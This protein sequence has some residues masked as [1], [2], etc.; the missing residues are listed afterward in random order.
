MEAGL[1]AIDW[2]R[3]W[4]APWRAEGE[5]AA[6]RVQA[7]A[8]VADAL[9]AQ[10]AAG[11]CRGTPATEPGVA[12][13]P[14][15]CLPAGQAYESFI[16]THRQVPTRDN[17]H[18][19]FNGLVWL[20]YPEAKRRMNQLQAEAIAAQGVGAVRGP[21]RDA[22]TVFDENGALW[23]APAPLRAALLARDW[24]GLFVRHR[25]LWAQARL[26]LFGHALLEKLVTPY[27]SVI[28]HVLVLPEQPP[29]HPAD[30]AWLA[31]ALQ[32]GVWR[33]KPFA[34]LPVL[35][36][37]GWWA[38]NEDPAFYDDTAVFRPQAARSR[39]IPA[40]AGA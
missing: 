40:I 14:Q 7:G 1:S 32:H 19:F 15:H 35:G 31:Q 18:D 37:P 3:P 25:A 29:E 2:Q 33:T 10:A 4:L 8:S 22:L 34:P 6:A 26:V 9:A 30:D 21:L 24:H 28:A 23:S 27:K 5:A 36:V 20:R 11:A 38:A 17:L 16:R 39:Q 13:V 12:F